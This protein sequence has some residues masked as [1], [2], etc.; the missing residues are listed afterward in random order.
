MFLDVR[1]GLTGEWLLQMETD[2][3]LS[4]WDVMSKV[5]AFLELET[6]YQITVNPEGTITTSAQESTFG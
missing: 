1:H 4:G 5:V 2:S 6:P 3:N